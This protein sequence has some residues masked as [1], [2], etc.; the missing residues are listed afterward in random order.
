MFRCAILS[1]VVAIG[2]AFLGFTRMVPP[3]G[4]L[5]AQT[6]FLA[7]IAI[8]TLASLRVVFDPDFRQ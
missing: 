8:F 4:S 5:L 3:A 1:L 6:V 2:A 7:A